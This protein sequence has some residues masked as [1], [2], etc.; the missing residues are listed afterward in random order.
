MFFRNRTSKNSMELHFFRQ[1]HF[2]GDTRSGGIRRES[3]HISLDIKNRGELDK[4]RN[5]YIK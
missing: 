5:S 3:F 1:L 2:D 4:S